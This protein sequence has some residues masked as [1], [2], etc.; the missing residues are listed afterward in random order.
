MDT[1][2]IMCYVITF[3]DLN[4]DE[5]NNIALVPTCLHGAGVDGHDREED[6]ADDVDD[7]QPD[8][9]LKPETT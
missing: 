7:G 2:L 9:Y 1:Y 6:G 5:S 3:N 8:P 4:K